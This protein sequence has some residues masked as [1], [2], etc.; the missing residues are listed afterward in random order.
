MLVPS[1]PLA[2]NIP[3]S[4][5]TFDDQSPEANTEQASFDYYVTAVALINGNL[6]E[7]AIVF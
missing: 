4:T 1:T 6:V 3:A 2:A 5:Y 7:S